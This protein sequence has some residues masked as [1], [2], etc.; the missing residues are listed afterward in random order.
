MPAQKPF[1]TVIAL[2][3]ALSVVTI[4]CSKK[5]SDKVAEAQ[6]CLDSSDSSNVFSCLE[7]VEGVDSEAANLIR[8]SASFIYQEFTDPAR[9]TSISEQMKTS[10]ASSSAVALGLLSFSKTY[11]ASTALQLANAALSYCTAAKSKGM[12]LLAGMAAIATE[13]NAAGGGAVVTSCDT[14]DPG[15]SAANCQTAVQGAVCA[16]SDTTVGNAALAAYQQG[17]V[18]SSQSNSSVCQ[19]FAAASAA[20]SDPSDVGAALKDQI[21]QGGGCPP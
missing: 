9:L 4:S 5:D 6:A 13:V 17:C 19:Q 20:S 18:G 1:P 15:Y 10:G 2:L 14:S 7:K 3:I 12:L 11:G 16:S 8:C 21:K